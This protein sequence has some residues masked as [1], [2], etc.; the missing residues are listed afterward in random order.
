[1]LDALTSV[2]FTAS[3]CL[4]P[5]V[6]SQLE[7][8]NTSVEKL[9]GQVSGLEE[10]ATKDHGDLSTLRKS[11]ANAERRA[12][13]AEAE[14]LRLKAETDA[15]L[16]QL[17][18]VSDQLGLVRACVRCCMVDPVLRRKR[19]WTDLLLLRRSW[20]AREHDVRSCWRRKTPPFVKPRACST[21]SPRN[22]RSQ[23]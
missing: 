2:V 9:R 4:I 23:A 13:E 19:I 12:Q 1:M 5:H 21:T 18:D 15:S 11:Q 7:D 14:M 17:R 22:W 3:R 10:Q 20:R 16:Q 8:A 6:C